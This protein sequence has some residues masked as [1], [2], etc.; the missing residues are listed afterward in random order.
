MRGALPIVRKHHYVWA[1]YLSGWSDKN[2][3]SI[4]HETSK[5]NISK[6][7]VKGLSREDD[8]NKIHAL[9]DRD[10]AY[11]ELWPSGDSPTLQNFQ[12]SQLDFFK[13]ASSIIDSHVGLEHLKEYAEIKNIAESIKY[14]LFEKTH[15]II[16][17]L[18]RP[19][20]DELKAGNVECLKQG[21][22]MT[23]FCNFLAQQLLRT[24]KAKKK[25]LE[26]MYLLPE[27]TLGVAAFKELYERNWWFLSYKLALNLG[28]SLHAS[29][30]TDHHTFITNKTSIDFITSDCPV[31]NIHESSHGNTVGKPPEKLDLYFPISPKTAYI[32]SSDSRYNKLASS[33]DE[34]EVK[35]LNT[36]IM[37]NS[38]LS[39]YGTSRD[40]IKDAR[41]NYR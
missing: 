21:K 34:K 18:A 2:D 4:W 9:S 24:K 32:I 10:V 27:N 16:E 35:N 41:Q 14:G 26:G 37:Q 20:I 40:S 3:K 22:Y 38:H 36:R 25:C 23:S 30:T 12:K 33:I 8:Y 11:I 17:N 5:G 15:T 31:I 29:S 19:V 1:Y 7:S 6:D 13:K 28:Y 39:I